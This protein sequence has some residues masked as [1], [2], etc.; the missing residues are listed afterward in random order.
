M[1][2]L[3]HVYWRHLQLSV[4]WYPD[5]YPKLTLNKH[6]IGIWSILGRHSINTLVDTW[7]TLHQHLSHQSVEN[8]L[9]LVWCTRVAQHSAHYWPTVDWMSIK[10]IIMLIKFQPS[11]DQDANR[12]PMEMMIVGSTL[13]HGRLWY[14]LL[15]VDV[16]LDNVSP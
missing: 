5:R 15:R 10:M 7:L 13:S 4:D 8:Q 3:D 16:H 11:I 14:L 6:L 9:I 12:V 1:E 2:L